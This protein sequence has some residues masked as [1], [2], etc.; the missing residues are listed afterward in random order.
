MDKDY[1]QFV[2]SS[3]PQ[4]DKKNLPGSAYEEVDKGDGVEGG[5]QGKQTPSRSL[6]PPPL[7]PHLLHDTLSG[8]HLVNKIGNGKTTSDQ[9]VVGVF[10]RRKKAIHRVW[11]VYSGFQGPLVVGAAA[12]A[13]FSSQI[14][15]NRHNRLHS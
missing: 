3:L 14:E 4:R 8:Y 5:G 1:Q 2:Q 12:T 11:N 10:T 7:E 15:C 13:A 9:S 6:Q